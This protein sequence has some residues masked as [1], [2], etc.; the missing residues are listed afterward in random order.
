MALHPASL[1]IKGE[2]LHDFPDSQK[3][4]RRYFQIAGIT[5]CVESDLD[6]NRIKFK[7]ALLAFSVD[8]PGEDNVIFRHYFEIPGLEGIDLGQE[9]YRK[10]PWSIYRKGDSWIYLGI[11]PPGLGGAFHKV[12]IFSNDYR[13][14]IIHNSLQEKENILKNVWRSLSLFPTDQIWLGPLLADR[15]AV[16][17]HAAG[18]IVN[19]KGLAFVGH[20]DAGKST[21]MELLKSNF[22]AKSLP[23]EIL[24]DDRVVVRNWTGSWHIHGTW[25]HGTTTDVSP[26]SAPLQ[27]IF[28]L[29][30]ALDNKIT[31]LIERKLI[32]SKLLATLVK[33]MMTAEWWT[34]EL[35]ILE[36]LIK[37]V[38]CYTMF[39]DKS[40]AII[41]EL[42]RL[43]R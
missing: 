15:Q 1:S 7:D 16:L 30:Q 42:E 36:Q 19:T 10:P 21:A 29:E 6:F 20:S 26:S 34:K 28:F 43:V 2:Q 3:I 5:V 25:S 8:G 18:A 40:G 41:P 37:E 27:A 23:V 22:R 9:L 17:L 38:P 24:C 33:P 39:F 14:A 31:P 35:V 4:Y 11:M 13:R 32:W 12:A